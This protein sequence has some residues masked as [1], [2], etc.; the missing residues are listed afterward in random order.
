MPL[1][2]R[3]LD[4]D[5]FA[6]LAR[7][8][9]EAREAGEPEPDAVVLATADAAGVVGA[10]T[11]NLVHADAHGLVWLTSH[12]SR[13][14]RD[15]AENPRAALV[16]LW[17]VARRQV[18][19]EGVVARLS[20]AEADEAWRRHPLRRRRAEAG[21]R[22]GA[23]IASREDLDAQARAAEEAGLDAR[24]RGWGGHRLAPDRFELWQ[25]VEDGLHDRFEYARVGGAWRLERLQP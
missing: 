2:R 19:V 15:L 18:R 16:F 7:W 12:E 22:Q 1:H 20:E 14:S 25:E 4:A 10:R 3:D 23:P 17:L 24:P 13:K 9:A 6:Q 11:V 8:R 5:P 21:V